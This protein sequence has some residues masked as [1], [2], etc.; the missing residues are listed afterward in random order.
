[1]QGRKLRAGLLGGLGALLGR[2]QGSETSAVHDTHQV[3]HPMPSGISG[4]AT[5]NGSLFS[6]VL[7][8]A[9]STDMYS[10]SILRPSVNLSC[11][12]MRL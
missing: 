4:S 9:A 12:A 8:I 3:H 5:A 6:R 11:H 10:A 1:M 7:S 2:R